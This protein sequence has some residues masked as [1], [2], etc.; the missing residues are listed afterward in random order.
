MTKFRGKR[1]SNRSLSSD[2]EDFNEDIIEETVQRLLSVYHAEGYP[3]AQIAPVATE[4]DENWIHL[5]FFVF[6][7]PPVWVGRSP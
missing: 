5:T 1:F 2:T 6:E 4:E 3:F 7:G